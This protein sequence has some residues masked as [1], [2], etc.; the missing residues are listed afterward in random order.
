VNDD[1]ADGRVAA[2][3]GTSQHDEHSGH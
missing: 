1:D 3:A 2:A